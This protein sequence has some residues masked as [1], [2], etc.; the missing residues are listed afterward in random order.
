MLQRHGAERDSWQRETEFS[1]LPFFLFS[2]LTYLVLD[3][4][5][6]Q[7]GGRRRREPEGFGVLGLVCPLPSISAASFSGTQNWPSILCRISILCRAPQANL[8]STPCLYFSNSSF[9]RIRILSLEIFQLEFSCLSDNFFMRSSPI[10][11]AP[12]HVCVF[13]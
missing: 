5:R 4:T 11:I 12:D 6:L 13:H 8:G 7:D 1:K 9:F 10:K 2:W 3:C